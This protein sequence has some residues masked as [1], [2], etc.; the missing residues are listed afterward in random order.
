MAITR[1]GLTGAMAGALATSSLAVP[2]IA[3]TKPIRFGWLA[4]LTGPNSSPGIGFNRGVMF[5]ANKINAAGGVKGRK[6]TII[7]RDTGGDPTKGVDAATELAAR[8]KVDAVFGPT[9]SGVSLATTPIFARFKVPNTHPDVVDRL[10]NPALYPNA[11]RLAPSNTQWDDANRKYCLDILKAKKIA[12]VGDNTGYGTTAVDAS[13]KAFE[14]AGAKVVYHAVIDAN[15]A[16]PSPELL[17]AKGAGAEVVTIWSD[18]AG[19]DARLMNARGQIGWD[20]VFT[21]HP[22]LGSGSVAHLLEKP[23]YWDKVYMVGY[24]S[25]SYDAAGKLPERSATF[26]AGLEG[27]VNLTDTLLWWVACGADAVNL[28]AAA[29]R[30]TGSSASKDIIGYWNTLKNWPGNFGDYTF[31]PTEHNGYPTD[32]VV[33]SK[34]NSFR[35]G[36]FDEAPGYT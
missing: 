3:E 32:E 35:N 25:C 24:K 26:V 1:R 7:T 36:A 21:G 12:V 28:V 8:L 16:D 20:V 14:K 29:V 23:A 27:K 34:A 11:F 10:I 22:A 19:L 33:M 2:A 15:A 4:A 17:R 9:N 5:A 6:F 31:T 13:T 30:E 18:S